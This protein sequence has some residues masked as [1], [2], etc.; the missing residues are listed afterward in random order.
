MIIKKLPNLINL[1]NLNLKKIM[2]G[3]LSYKFNN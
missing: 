2:D 3:K 1:L